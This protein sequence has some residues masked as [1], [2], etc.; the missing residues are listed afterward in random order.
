M[1]VIFSRAPATL[2]GYVAREE[3]LL[4][5]NALTF[6]AEEGGPNR[7]QQSFT[8]IQ[9]DFKEKRDDTGTPPTWLDLSQTP[10]SYPPPDRLPEIQATVNTRSLSAGIHQA[11]VRVGT[12]PA[13]EPTT[14][15]S[16][17]ATTHIKP[18]GTGPGLTISKAGLLFTSLTGANPEV[19]TMRLCNQSTVAINWRSTIPPAQA[20]LMVLA[21]A[22]GTL[23][24]ATRA[25]A[26][27]GRREL[28]S[29]RRLG[30]RLLRRTAS[31]TRTRRCAWFRARRALCA[32]RFGPGMRLARRIR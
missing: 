6:L 29:G 4:S 8:T 24:A 20:Q 18:R 12:T 1:T 15:A 23:A 14:C 21:P 32:L 11:E 26:G 9:I 25:L 5:T 19:E 22:Q 7:Q 30:L 27:G 13:D 16:L 17:V 2:H 10:G 3:P 28:R 31:T